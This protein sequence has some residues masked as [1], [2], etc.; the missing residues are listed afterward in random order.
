VELTQ[1]YVRWQALVLA[2][3]NL[4][5]LLPECAVIWPICNE[6]SP[7]QVEERTMHRPASPLES[8]QID[9]IVRATH[10]LRSLVLRFSGLDVV[11]FDNNESEPYYSGSV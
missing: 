3:L 8:V 6:G 1:D 4:P 2:V 7:I 11:C 5:V 10:Q 9:V